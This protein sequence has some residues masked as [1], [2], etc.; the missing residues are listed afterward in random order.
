MLICCCPQPFT[1]NCAAPQMPI[2]AQAGYAETTDTIT[3][4]LSMLLPDDYHFYTPYKV[5]LPLIPLC[6]KDPKCP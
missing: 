4:R 5:T 6:N 1:L 2:G 3:Q